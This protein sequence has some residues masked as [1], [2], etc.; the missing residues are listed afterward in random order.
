MLD[1]IETATQCIYLQTYK[2]GNDYIGKKFKTALLKKA[3]QGVEINLLLDS[4][5]SGASGEA[6]FK[7]LKKAGV[8]ITYFEKIKFSFD[9]FSR[10]HRRNH[11][12]LLLIDDD[13]S[14]IGSSNITAHCLNWRECAIKISGG[15]NKTLRKII[16]DDIDFSNNFFQNKKESTELIKYR[17]TEIV[18]DVPSNRFQPVKEKYIELINSAQ[19]SVVIE[20]PY[21][22]PGKK[23]RKSIYIA[24]ERGVKIEIIVPKYSDVLLFDILRN[25]YLGRYYK[26]NIKMLF[27]KTDNLHAKVFL[28]DGKQYFTGSS[29]FDYRSMRFMHEIN[30][31]G[32]DKSLFSLLQEHIDNTKA[33]CEEFEFEKWKKRHTFQK[34]VE[35]LLVPFRHLF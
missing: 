26:N 14:Y 3:Q 23:L 6:Y 10:N 12:K 27:Y 25:K 29:N 9:L 1:D 18:R 8:E 33:E 11:R 4:W 35:G 19:E 20:T 34:I 28:V 7:D 24:S 22:L 5:G 16:I 13:I 32:S 30:I 15:I 17:N 21:F 31:L 2:F